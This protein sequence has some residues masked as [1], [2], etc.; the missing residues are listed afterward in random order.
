MKMGYTFACFMRNK[1]VFS[2]V[3]QLSAYKS[4]YF[5]FRISLYNKNKTCEEFCNLSNDYF[6]IFLSRFDMSIC[7]L[8]NSMFLKHE[9]ND[10]E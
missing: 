7:Q 5:L 10:N 1:T 8:F 2:Q 6:S 3:L 4:I 9:R